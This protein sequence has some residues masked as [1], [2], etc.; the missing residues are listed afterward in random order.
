[1]ST[2]TV[3]THK[4][5]V[6]RPMRERMQQ[7][8]VPYSTELLCR[9]RVETQTL[10]L[11]A[12][13]LSIQ[14]AELQATRRDQIKDVAA[15]AG[16]SVASSSQWRGV[17]DIESEK[18]FR[19]EK[20]NRELKVSFAEQMRIR[21]RILKTLEKA[22]ALEDIEFVL[23]LEP[24][25]QRPLCGPNFSELLLDEMS[26]NL[27]WLRLDT[28]MMLSVVDDSTTVSFRWQHIPLKNCIQSSSITPVSCTV[29][30]MGDMLWGHALTTKKALD[31]SFHYVRRNTPTPLDMNAV[32]SMVEGP[33]CTNAVT[34]FRKYD[35]GDRIIVVGTTKWFLPSGELLLQD[36]SWTVVSPSPVNRCVIRHCYN[37]EVA[38]TASNDAAQAQKLMFHAVSGKMRSVYLAIQD[39]L[40][41]HIDLGQI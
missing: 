11:E 32:A 22:K 34:T 33:L 24:K 28:D 17:A 38:A 31:R 35:E 2:G 10:Q 6:R 18:R 21:T 5:Q 8:G 40:L 3:T 13:A 29:Q 23:Q 41:R 36:Y 12:Q 7:R 1:M 19:A 20:V 25:I 27:D 9:K 26:T 30:Q 39:N 4:E 37:L 16:V 15:L 14:L